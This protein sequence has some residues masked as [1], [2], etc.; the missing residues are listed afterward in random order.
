MDLISRLFR[1]WSL[2]NNSHINSNI[3]VVVTTL[4]GSSI[5]AK[6]GAEQQKTQQCVLDV[7]NDNNRTKSAV[8]QLL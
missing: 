6:A 4:V 1:I 2:H 7:D 8:L 3:P 5:K